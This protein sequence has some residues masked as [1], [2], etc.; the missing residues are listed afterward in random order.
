MW[1]H[2]ARNHTGFA[3]EFQLTKLLSE[4]D[5]SAALEVEYAELE[6]TLPQLYSV[7]ELASDLVGERK[8]RHSTTGFDRYVRYKSEDW[9]Y[10][11]EVRLGLRDYSVTEEGQPVTLRPYGISLKRV[12]AGC[13]ASNRNIDL[14]KTLLPAQTVIAR[15]RR[16][17]DKFAVDLE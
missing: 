11:Q 2:Y 15:A 10:E 8:L 12:I 5:A 4:T 17:P 3:F 1:S 6:A 9:R 14:I 7:E 16:S 13:R